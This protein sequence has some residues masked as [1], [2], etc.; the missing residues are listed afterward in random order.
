MS[1]CYRWLKKSSPIDQYLSGWIASSAF[2]LQNLFPSSDIC[3]SN[4]AVGLISILIDDVVKACVSDGPVA[5]AEI[6]D[7]RL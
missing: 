4:G 3:F 5:E 7:A 2:C 1:C 6:D